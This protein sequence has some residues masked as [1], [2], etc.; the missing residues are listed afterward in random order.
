V[1]LKREN[2]AVSITLGINV[3]MPKAGILKL[4]AK[5]LTLRPRDLGIRS[6]LWP[7]H[8]RNGSADSRALHSQIK[9]NT[10]PR[11]L[12]LSTHSQ[13]RCKAKPLKSLTLHSHN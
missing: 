6:A 12:K 5:V 1:A 8:S 4:T 10:S 7:S 13:I 11:I 9:C 3:R 2:A